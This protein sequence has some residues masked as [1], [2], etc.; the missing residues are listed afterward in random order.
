MKALIISFFCIILG[1]SFIFDRKEEVKSSPIMNQ[2]EIKDVDIEVA[3]KV[4]YADTLDYF[5]QKR[6]VIHPDEA[7]DPIF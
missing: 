5:A 3:R 1:Y 2:S 4:Y 6:F 7:I